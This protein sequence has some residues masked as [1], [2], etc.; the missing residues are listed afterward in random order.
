[1]SELNLDAFFRYASSSIVQR[2][3]RYYRQNR[4]KISQVDSKSA[5]IKVSG[6]MITPYTVHMEFE[7]SAKPYPF[8][9]TCTCPHAYDMPM[10]VCKHKVAALL[11]LRDYREQH[12]SIDWRRTLESAKIHDT[13]Q[14]PVKKEDVLFFSLQDFYGDWRIIPYTLPGEVFD[15]ASL[16]DPDETN[17]TI[18]EN[19]LSA[20]AKRI[21][22][23]RNMS[24]YTNASSLHLT[25][26]SLLLDS[27]KYDYLPSRSIETYLPMLHGTLLYLGNETDP[28]K[29]PVTISKEHGKFDVIIDKSET[30]IHISGLIILNDSEIN[31]V[32]SDIKPLNA[33]FTWFIANNTI[34]NLEK[35]PLMET[36]LQGD[37]E[38]DDKDKDDFVAFYLPDIIERYEIRGDLFS[39]LNDIQVEPTP[40]L[41]LTEENK[42]LDIQ[43]KFAYDKYEVAYEKH[44]PTKSIRPGLD[45]GA[46]VYIHRMPVLEEEIYKSLGAEY[47]LKK[48][49]VSGHISLRSTASPLDFIYTQ[50]PK[51]TAKGFEIFGEENLSELKLNRNKPKLTM[52]VSSGIDWFD[53]DMVIDYGD[54][55]VSMA[56]FRKALKKNQ[57][58]I[59]LSDGTT[60]R[61]PDDWVQ[62]YR[63]LMNLGVTQDG[64]LKISS[65]QISLIDS[66]LEEVDHYELDNSF[67]EQ[68]ERLLGF[69]GI[70]DKILPQGFVGKLRDYQKSGYDWLHFLHEFRFGGCLSDDM[71]VGKTIQ[72][73]VFIQS[74]RESGHSQTADLIVMP[75]SLLTNWEREAARFTPNMRV[76]IH[77]GPDRSI[78][79]SD[80]DKYDIVLTTYGIMRRDIEMFR[81][82]N[83]H[84]A[85]LDE[86]QAIKNPLAATGKA[87]R[88]LNCDH[89]LVLTGTPVENT[90]VDLWSQFAFINPGML[91]SHEYFRSEFSGPI[92]RNKDDISAKQ[93]RSL[94][95]PFILRR[96]KEQVAPELPPRVESI[97]YCEMEHTQQKMYNKWRDRYR[98]MLLGIIKDENPQ[99]VRMKVLEGLLRLRQICIHPGLIDADYKGASAK[100][101]ALI[102]TLETLKSEGRKALIFSQ[103][104]S[105]LKI[106]A[107]EMQK[108]K[109]SYVY[110]DGRTRDR[111]SVIDSFQNDPSISFF[112]I[113]LKAGGV[114][115]NLTAADHV[116][117]LDPW[118][119]PAVERQ[120][121]DRTHRIGQDKPVFIQKMIAKDSVEEKIL[122]LQD[123]KRELA[124]QIISSE[125]SFI[126]KIT[127]EDITALFS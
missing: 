13:S 38:I 28:L 91:G 109:L 116:I 5:K 25:L 54:I 92:E 59:K 124:D 80:F 30:G 103:F 34:F 119:N 43:L 88:C 60:G 125:K 17:I 3:I 50:I 118:W 55:Q 75:K 29:Q 37:I 32:G 106:V 40:R 65:V 85:I 21:Y 67:I 64:K 112:L 84:Y 10:L 15:I 127:A 58:Y 79:E 20:A 6:S 71:G 46:L 57:Q 104:T 102:E 36:L 42:T 19:R 94:V 82:Y 66:I 63:H 51:L 68:R 121:S 12:P 33:N 44:L 90:T 98:A 81:R 24:R 105:A 110:L 120:A 8:R 16:S 39:G 18:T 100:T 45:D 87:A 49:I 22:D 117:H 74:L 95:H 48:A 93:L 56:D 89:R 96:T 99:N 86:S 4:V 9:I 2:G 115:L 101:E 122:I 27:Y 107:A 114:G 111:Q 72:A 70:S 52:N 97:I 31:L 73:L 62:K 41:Y 108:T 77:S 113:S 26:L 61:I 14:K 76:L 35:S 47:G 11:S 78:Q 53:V 123:S 83:F 23:R 69:T 7:R 1:M 126:K